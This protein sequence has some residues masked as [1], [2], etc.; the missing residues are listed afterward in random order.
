MR[1]A[2]LSEVGQTA[3]LLNNQ[4]SLATLRTEGRRS[5]TNT[6]LRNRFRGKSELISDQPVSRLFEDIEPIY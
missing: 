1:K 6:Q 3:E 4:F 5:R 2:A